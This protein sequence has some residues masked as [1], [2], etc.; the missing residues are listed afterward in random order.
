MKHTEPT[1]DEIKILHDPTGGKKE[2]A[3]VEIDG[4]IVA[5][6]EDALRKALDENEI[7]YP[8]NSG[9]NKLAKRL[10]KY[11]EYYKVEDIKNKKDTKPETKA[12]DKES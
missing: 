4:N 9:I 11:Y 8:D 1:V 6:S 7:Y 10:Q 5:M 2:F 3:D 12:E